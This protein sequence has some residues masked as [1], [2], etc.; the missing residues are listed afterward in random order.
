MSGKITA[1]IRT[2]RRAAWIGLALVGV[3]RLRSRMH[4]RVAAL[5]ALY[6]AISYANY[7]GSRGIV[8]EVLGVGV[9]ILLGVGELLTATVLAASLLQG[10]LPAMNA[11]TWRNSE[12]ERILITARE[13]LGDEQYQ[14]M[15]DRGASMSYEEVVEFALND[16]HRARAETTDA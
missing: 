8:V 5:E 1:M 9:D 14:R 12:L 15:F 10:P 7:V 4:D 16:V 6:D 13:A 2:M 11:A 3:A